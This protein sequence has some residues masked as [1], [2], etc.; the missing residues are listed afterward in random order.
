MFLTTLREP[1]ITTYNEP[2]QSNSYIH[3]T[4]LREDSG[5]QMFVSKIFLNHVLIAIDRVPVQR[6]QPSK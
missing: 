3:V 2:Y 6:Q 5:S 1:H 4:L